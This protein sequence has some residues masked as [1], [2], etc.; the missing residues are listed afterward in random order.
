MIELFCISAAMLAPLVAERQQ[1]VAQLV[2]DQR[3]QFMADQAYL[4]HPHDPRVQEWK[5]VPG[6]TFE[7]V[8]WLPGIREKHD[9]ATCTPSGNKTNQPDFARELL[10]DAVAYSGA[11]TFRVRIWGRKTCSNEH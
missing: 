4:G 6:S 3:A 9:V 5:A 8:G 1:S 7:G 10:A 2:A 11:Y